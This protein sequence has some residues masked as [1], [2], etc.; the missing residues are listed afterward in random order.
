[1]LA[2]IIDQRASDYAALHLLA[3]CKPANHFTSLCQHLCIEGAAQFLSGRA[4]TVEFDQELEEL[5]W[6]LEW[7][8]ASKTAKNDFYEAC[9]L[10]PPH[11]PLQEKCQK[12]VRK[13]NTDWLKRVAQYDVWPTAKY[14]RRR[15][16]ASALYLSL[17][18][19]TLFTRANQWFADKQIAVPDPQQSFWAIYLQEEGAHVPNLKHHD[20]IVAW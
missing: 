3:K 9:G 5:F 17:Y 11:P 18:H 20:P 7:R 16:E 8:L 10:P 14:F 12:A 2:Q 6:D 4:Q 15:D 19:D 1:M 13:L